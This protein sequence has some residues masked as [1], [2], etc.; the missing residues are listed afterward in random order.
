MTEKA[1]QK[2]DSLVGLLA[3]LPG[4]KAKVTVKGL[5]VI[6]VDADA[7][8][9]EVETKG[10]REAGLRLSDLVEVSTG[11]SS[12]LRGSSKVTG[13]LSKSGWKVTLFAD[14]EKMLV[15]GSGVSR[16]TGRISVNPLKLRKLLKALQ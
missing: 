1:E 6:S 12:L 14:G 16:L 3:L 7:K 13:A 15:M 9:L 2:V 5:P 4:G 8:T 10:L 11:T